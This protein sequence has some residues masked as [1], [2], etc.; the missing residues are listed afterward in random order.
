M[1]TIHVA[2]DGRNWYGRK[3]YRIDLDSKV[4]TLKFRRRSRRNT[5]SLMED[6]TT[7]LIREERPYRI[8]GIKEL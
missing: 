5:L 3:L 1:I 2:R 7:Q 8:T 6:I 4:G